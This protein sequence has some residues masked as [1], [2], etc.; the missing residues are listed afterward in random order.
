MAEGVL[1][2]IA[3][4]IIKKLGSRAFCEMGLWWGVRD[5]LKKLEATVSSIH[6][7]LL[8]AEEQQKQNR[9]V[10]GWLEKLQE[11]VYDAD[12]LVDD[13]A[14]EALRRQVMTGN[15]LTKEVTLFFSS[16][17]RLVYGF[18]MGHKI[19][20]IREKLA[21]IEADR[22]FRLEVR[23]GERGYTTMVRDQTVSSV[24]EVVIGRE[25]DKKATVE[26]LLAS[27]SKGNVSVISIVGIGGL[28]KTT[29]AQ[30]IFNDER[31]KN[32][33]ELKIWVC[34]SDPFDV[35]IIVRKILETATCKKS[36]DLELEALTSQLGNIL[37]GKRYLLVLD[38]V[39]NE[40]CEK[41][42]NLKKILLGGSSGSKILVTT[43]SKIV[44]QIS[45]TEE[46]YLLEGLSPSKSWSLFLHVALRGQEPKDSKIKKIVE[47]I[48]KK[49]VGVPLAIKTI[50]SLLCY[51]YSENEWGTFLENELSKVPQNENDILPT[52]KLSY[53]HLSSPLKHCFAYCALFPKG[54][55]IDVKTL[56]H[57]WVAQGFIESSSSTDCADDIGL[58]YFM[59]LWW[60][61]FFQEVKRDKFGN[62]HFCKMHDLM[63]DL[64]TSITG[65]GTTINPVGLSNTRKLRT[66]LL[67]HQRFFLE[68]S[69]EM[70]I[71]LNFKK[72]RAFGVSGFGIK[73]VPNYIKRLKHLRYLD[74]SENYEIRTLPNSITNLQNLQVLNVSFCN[75]L[76]ELPKDIKKMINL[77]HLSWCSV[78]CPFQNFPVHER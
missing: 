76:M 61:S 34:V 39:W 5:E 47:E 77:R 36:E 42:D 54:Y 69:R 14:T 72:L 6:N 73:T 33:F 3:G 32:Y 19:K 63:H 40:D 60:R 27:N 12:D 7:M 1:F 18:K 17:N 4:E 41:W 46:P 56:I 26:L 45:S 15:R 71:H 11:I 52:L 49:C 65:I 78:S 51:K 37:N 28:G 43:R 9:Q 44:A 58:K 75:S 2:D 66:F 35:K 29:L 70:S 53:D 50:A 55:K 24:P 48:V 13:F 30:F 8:D 31:I 10:K 16:S 25:G 64:A 67:P 21:D 38:D 20:A 62:I 68:T 22:Q 59:E 23:T 74:V 57:L